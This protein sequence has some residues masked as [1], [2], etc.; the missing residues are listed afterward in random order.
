[1]S[2]I[3]SEYKSLFAT[4]KNDNNFSWHKPSLYKMV[5]DF[6]QRH[7]TLGTQ[8]EILENMKDDLMKAISEIE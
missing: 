4:I 3:L 8:A 2:A 6:V 1:M 5:D 7:R